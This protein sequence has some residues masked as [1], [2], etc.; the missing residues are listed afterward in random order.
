MRK[1]L[2][3]FLLS[4]ALTSQAQQSVVDSLQAALSQAKTD[5]A[6]VM[7][8]SQLS[9]QYF[10]FDLEKAVQHGE[11]AEKLAAKINFRKG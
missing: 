5:S 10:M 6:R 8:N 4:V 2:L 1:I 3:F 7:L 9:E 11:T